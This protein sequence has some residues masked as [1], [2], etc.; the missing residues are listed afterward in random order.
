M[1]KMEIAPARPDVPLFLEC[2]WNGLKLV[3]LEKARPPLPPQVL[4]PLP[5][6]LSDAEQLPDVGWFID[7]RSTSL[8]EKL[9]S[10]AELEPVLYEREESFVLEDSEFELEAGVPMEETPPLISS[11]EAKVSSGI[12]AQNSSTGI[13]G[14]P[15]EAVSTPSSG[16][17]SGNGKL[18]QDVKAELESWKNELESWG[19]KSE[20]KVVGVDKNTKKRTV[21]YVSVQVKESKSLKTGHPM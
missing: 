10:T 8:K 7:D 17:S 6:C 1:Q 9:Q 16:I 21:A 15:A 18:A 2:S 3:F 20:D 14:L 11:M 4:I 12:I 13:T 19:S 5:P